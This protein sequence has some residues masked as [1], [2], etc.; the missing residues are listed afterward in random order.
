MFYN[1]QKKNQI[2]SVSVCVSEKR[3][4]FVDVCSVRFF[5]FFPFLSRRDLQMLPVESSFKKPRMLNFADR[6]KG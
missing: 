3:S 6:H 2:R 4:F 1:M 5:F